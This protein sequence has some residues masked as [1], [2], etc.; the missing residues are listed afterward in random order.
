MFKQLNLTDLVAAVKDRIETG[1]E[2][3]CFDIPPENEPAPLVYVEVAGLRPADTKTMY[4][5]R[6]TLW[7]HVIAEEMKSH[8]PIYQYVEDVQEAMTEDIELP[9]GFNLV[10]QSDDGIQTI[11]TDESGEKHAV[12]EFEFV[13]SYGYKVK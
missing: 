3:P 4:C 9:E 6:Y 8:V 11:Q 5:K 7:L 2:L 1:T 10:Y 12:L 13:V